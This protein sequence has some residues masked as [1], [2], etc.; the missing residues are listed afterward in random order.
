VTRGSDTKPLDVLD[1]LWDELRR[2][3]L[4]NPGADYLVTSRGVEERRKGQVVA[5]WTPLHGRTAAG[6][7]R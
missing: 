6:G 2:Y 7:K 4:A 1:S 3:G 5:F